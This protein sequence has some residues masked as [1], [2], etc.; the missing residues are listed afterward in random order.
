MALHRVPFYI[1]GGP[2]GN[3]EHPADLVRQVQPFVGNG[4]KSAKALQPRA[5]STASNQIVLA[6][7][8]LIIQGKAQE[9]QG[10][11]ADFNSGDLF[12]TL[13]SNG[14]GSLRYD[15]VVI[16]VEDPDFEG[17]RDRMLDPIVFVEVITGVGSSARTLADAGKSGYS[18]IPIARV[19]RSSSSDTFSDAD[20]TDLRKLAQPRNEFLMDTVQHGDES[21][22]EAGTDV[23]T[24][25]VGDTDV[26]FPNT[27]E[28]FVDVP[29]YAVKM[30]VNTDIRGVNTND[31]TGGG[32]RDVLWGR[33][34]TE[35]DGT[36]HPGS[37]WSQDWYP[38]N[39]GF[40]LGHGLT[41]DVTALQGQRIRI[42]PIHEYLD[43][44]SFST[45]CTI[46]APG[47][48]V[49]TFSV[50]FREEVIPY[51]G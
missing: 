41:L 46:N 18:A 14:T 15:M 51:G 43:S 31:P 36:I 20:I 12:H 4:V 5:T 19:R 38:P 34:G 47:S 45:D 50:S 6:S 11:Y 2:E 40:N 48:T 25:N 49:T 28:M 37:G 13:P 35:V 9:H 30:V 10:P 39:S 24:I 8:G 33:I 42:R 16:R 1:G 27:A 26:W 32:T 3:P 23:Q 21:N 7:G 22:A 44:A 29:E 17:S